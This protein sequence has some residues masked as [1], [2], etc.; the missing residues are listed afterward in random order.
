MV[1]EKRSHE[2]VRHKT[3]YLPSFDYG[4]EKYNEYADAERSSAHS[5]SLVSRPGQPICAPDSLAPDSL[6]GDLLADLKRVPD[7]AESD[8]QNQ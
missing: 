5:P 2:C 1:A 4:P 8:N 6:H 3:G 7:C